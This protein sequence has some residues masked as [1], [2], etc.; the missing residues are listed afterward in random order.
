MLAKELKRKFDEIHQFLRRDVAK[1]ALDSVCA[2]L[3]DTASLIEAF[4]T[5][6]EKER[7]FLL[8][9]KLNEAASAFQERVAVDISK[10]IIDP[11]KKTMA[12][13]GSHRWTVCYS[14]V[15]NLLTS[16]RVYIRGANRFGSGTNAVE[17]IVEVSKTLD[18]FSKWC[19][20]MEDQFKSVGMA[21]R[22]PSIPAEKAELLSMKR[23][24]DV[25]VAALSQARTIQMQEHVNNHVE[26]SLVDVMRQCGEA[27]WTKAVDAMVT[28]MEASERAIKKR[29]DHVVMTEAWQ[30]VDEEIESFIEWCKRELA[31]FSSAAERS[32]AN[33]F[34]VT[35]VAAA[36]EALE[37]RMG[38]AAQGG[39]RDEAN[40]KMKL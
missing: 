26:K 2:L 18:D 12:T 17:K 23:A 16:I 32:A 19:M 34:C 22:F 15:D 37:K 7:E 6:A 10:M 9:H 36:S 30:K 5:F 28:H 8:S 24:T 3:R 29:N 39:L 38:N 1:D 31:E 4:C 13:C 27:R 21:P 25:G 11:L 20:A 40:T 14:A 35:C 33:E